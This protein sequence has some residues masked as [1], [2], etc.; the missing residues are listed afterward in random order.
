MPTN[1]RIKN[2]T[3]RTTQDN[4]NPQRGTIVQQEHKETHIVLKGACLSNKDQA[5]N[6][7]KKRPFS[8]KT[9]LKQ[10]DPPYLRRV[11][12]YH[13]SFLKEYMVTAQ[14]LLN[15]LPLR[16]TTYHEPNDKNHNQNQNKPSARQINTHCRSL[17]LIL[18]PARKQKPHSGRFS[19]LYLVS[20]FPFQTTH[21]ISIMACPLPVKSGRHVNGRIHA[22]GMV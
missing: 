3:E 20:L 15:P 10:K 1:P 7:N 16:Q 6:Q 17:L 9:R 18:L 13:H 5:T 21:D 11:F 8:P 4:M 19:G 22:G 2:K 14:S 12:S